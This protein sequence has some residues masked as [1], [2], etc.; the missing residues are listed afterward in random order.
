MFLDTGPNPT[1]EKLAG[2]F[3][4]SPRL[5][6][7]HSNSTGSLSSLGSVTDGPFRPTPAPLRLRYRAFVGLDVDDPE[8]V[9]REAAADTYAN[10]GKILNLVFLAVRHWWQG[11]PRQSWR[12]NNVAR[13]DRKKTCRGLG[14]RIGRSLVPRP[15]VI[16]TA[17]SRSS[18]SDVDFD[19]SSPVADTSGPGTLASGTPLL[20]R[21]FLTRNTRS[22]E[23]CLFVIRG[24]ALACSAAQLDVDPV[25]L[26]QRDQFFVK[27]VLVLDLEQVPVDVVIE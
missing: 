17:R 21:Y 5:C 24:T 26:Q 19:S 18:S 2:S 8:G 1:V 9:N 20:I 13:V 27:I 3:W 10:A 7:V 22:S 4:N 25:S 6:F 15:S 14:S 16:R 23:S 11:Q 12:D